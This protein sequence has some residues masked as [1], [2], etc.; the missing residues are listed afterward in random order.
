MLECIYSVKNITS[1]LLSLLLLQIPVP[2]SA[3]FYHMCMHMS[4]CWCVIQVAV[5]VLVAKILS[6]PERVNN[7][8]IEFLRKLV[9]NGPDKHPG[10]NFVQVQGQ[11]FKKCAVLP[12]MS[13]FAAIN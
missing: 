3:F 1:F 13:C 4:M 7:S 12:I 6:Y 2:L 11:N 8:N 9:V 5:P 10:A